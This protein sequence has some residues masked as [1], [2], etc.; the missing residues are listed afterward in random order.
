MF[1]YLFQPEAKDDMSVFESVVP[2]EMRAKVVVR[3]ATRK[4]SQSIPQALLGD[5]LAL[6]ELPGYP[7]PLWKTALFSVP[8]GLVWYVQIFIQAP[9]WK[10]AGCGT[11]RCLCKHPGLQGYLT[12]LYC[13]LMN[14]RGLYVRILAILALL[15]LNK[16]LIISTPPERVRI[17]ET[18]EI[19]KPRFM[20]K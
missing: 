3:P 16:R 5:A 18:S 12:T 13:F 4:V 19:S 1:L 9:S 14:M 10:H 6:P 8:T 2:A 11:C 15:T 17:S 7:R 20:R